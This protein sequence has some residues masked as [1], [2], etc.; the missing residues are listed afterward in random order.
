M[1]DLT[2]EGLMD[3]ADSFLRDAPDDWGDNSLFDLLNEADRRKLLKR[4]TT[5]F[6]ALVAEARRAQWEADVRQCESIA[7]A[8]SERTRGRPT[9]G[10]YEIGARNCA[11]AIR[12]QKETP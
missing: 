2:P 3:R 9:S 12:V 8:E 11:A 5:T 10:E 6:T 4:L 7:R 1:T